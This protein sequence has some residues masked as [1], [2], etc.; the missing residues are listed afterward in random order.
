MKKLCPVIAVL[1]VLTACS[2]APRD[3]EPSALSGALL[4]S[5]AFSEA[6]AQTDTQIGLYLYELSPDTVEDAV[7]Y[8]SSG[9]TAEEIAVFKACSAADAEVIASAVRARISS[10]RDSFADYNPAEVPKLD[11]AVLKVSGVYVVFYVAD[12]YAAAAN[13]AGEYI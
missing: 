7:F 10:Q 4:E 2:S 11:N 6:I 1:L 3:F 12:D 13:A 5:G 9:A 8:F